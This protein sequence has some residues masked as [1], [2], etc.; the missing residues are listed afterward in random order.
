[1]S[2]REAMTEIE[3]LD[4]AVRLNVASDFRTF[5][6][7]AR[8]HRAV[9]S[10]YRELASAEVSKK[11]VS[12]V[13]ELSRQAI[14]LRYENQ[15]DTAL[16]VYVWLISL[17]DT[18]FSRIAAEVAVQAPQC[19][20]ATRLARSILV[21]E[22]AYNTAG[23]E[24]VDLTS[25]TL[26]AASTGDISGIGAIFLSP[27]L[28]DLSRATL[29]TAVSTGHMVQVSPAL[30]AGYLVEPTSSKFSFKNQRYETLA[31]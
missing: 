12:R 2:V 26:T 5:I 7:A 17:R 3:S 29:I 23:L 24:L 9:K 21:G 11:I 30:S 14:D 27:P 25:I 1:M 16:A 10:L 19:W 4:F 8:Q 6:Q 20:W 13:A 22:Q 28:G 15:W 18:S 31:A